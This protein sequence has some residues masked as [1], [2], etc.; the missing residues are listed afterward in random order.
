MKL[1]KYNRDH[2]V[3]LRVNRKMAATIVAR[4]YQEYGI[5]STDEFGMAIKLYLD[6][7]SF[8]EAEKA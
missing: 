1:G 3:P 2:E 8:G 5:E 4:R 7:V 6:G